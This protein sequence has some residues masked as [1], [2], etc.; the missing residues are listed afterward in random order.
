MTAGASFHVVTVGWP[1]VLIEGLCTDIAARSKARFSHI[2]HPRHVADSWSGRAA[3]GAIR[4]FRE[5]MSEKLPLADVHLLASLEQEGV[6]TIHNMLLGDR[7]VCRLDYAQAQRYATFI[8]RRLLVLYDELRP[9]VVIGGFDSLHGG[10]ALAVARRAGIPWFA[11][12]FSVLPRGLACFC[13]RMSPAARVQL[14]SRPRSELGSLAESALHQFEERKIQAYAY[15]PPR[16][17]LARSVSKI[18]TRAASISRA[19]RKRLDREF[20]QFVEVEARYDPMAALRQLR[21][22]RRA[23][24]AIA[25]TKA[26]SGPPSSPF[27]FFGLHMQPESSIDVWAPF[28]SN[29]MWVIETLSRCLPPT[30]KL[31]VKIHKSDVSNHSGEELARMRSF[32]GVELVQPSADSRNFIAKADLVVAIQGTIG[33]EAALLGRPVVLLGESPVAVFPSASQAG[34]LTELPRLVRQK[35]SEQPVRRDEIVDAYASY[36]APFLP[37]SHNDW[38]RKVSEQEVE[39]YVRLFEELE[40]YLAVKSGRRNA[41]N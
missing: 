29:Q 6:P 32:P 35:L 21:L 7:V 12:H 13:D 15:S 39:A 4:F 23:R 14:A 16:R 41:T 18:P 9:S 38:T 37:A 40:R 30:H 3:A 22:A 11:L 5:T 8:A 20:A 31:L 2:P 24:L 10:L 1:Q 25:A 34:T 19:L 33:L 27:V 28:Y 17:S 26:V 36:L